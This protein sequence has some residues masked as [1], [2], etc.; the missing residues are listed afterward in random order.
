MHLHV[1]ISSHTLF[2]WMYSEAGDPCI[3]QDGFTGPHCQYIEDDTMVPDCPLDCENGGLCTL[4]DQPTYFEDEVSHAYC[5]CPD[6]YT[7]AFCELKKEPCGND[8]CLHGGTCVDRFVNGEVKFSC[9]C[10]EAG[11]GIDS[12]GGRYCQFKAERYC[13][14]A[15]DADGPF[16]CT[17]GGFCKDASHKGCSCPEGFSGFSCEFVSGPIPVEGDE[18]AGDGNPEP[19][20]MPTDPSEYTSCNL[21]CENEGFCRKGVKD[22]GFLEPYT[23]NVSH[24]NETHNEDFE[25]CVCPEGYTGLTCDHKVEICG[26]NEHV[27]FHGSKCV[28]NDGVH[29]C[30]CRTT[31]STIADR[32]A[33]DSCEHLSTDI[34][35]D[36]DLLPG[37]TAGFCTNG[38]ICIDYVKPGLPHPG[39]SCPPFWRG[40][41]CEIYLGHGAPR[42]FANPEDDKNPGVVIFLALLF[43]GVLGGG[44]F[45]YR[46]MGRRQQRRNDIMT[47]TLAWASRYQDEKPEVNLA[48]RRS[49][50]INEGYI[51]DV[52]LDSVRGNESAGV[53]FSTRQSFT[54]VE[55]GG[56]A[57]PIDTSADLLD[58]GDSPPEIYL[59]PPTDEDG[60]ELHNVDIL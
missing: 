25:H 3:C 50:S 27:C 22:V 17:N 51:E 42:G 9:D 12:Y 32:F 47:K 15:S 5:Q 36:G 33:G 11:D 10:S 28:S 37:Q 49:S 40:S 23:E 59:G 35:V 34:C 48:P 38:G 52:Y 7:G 21:V 57:A 44:Y 60:H 2:W 20:L 53:S 41:H 29:A 18:G 1:R 14:N 46:S 26:E 8:Y 16:F 43:V 6:H 39:C 54:A 13:P 55:S 24:L 58:D 45:M 30:D 56:P 31:D 4:G 19:P